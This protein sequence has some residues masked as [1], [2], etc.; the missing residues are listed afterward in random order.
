M[1]QEVLRA[2]T[3]KN[4]I[5]GFVSVDLGC[6]LLSDPPAMQWKLLPPKETPEMT[7]L[8]K[9]LP[10]QGLLRP[11]GISPGELAEREG[12]NEHHCPPGGR[13]GGDPVEA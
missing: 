2:T 8:V 10:F 5:P 1:L 3:R 4:E 7:R 13:N 11:F 6:V 12:T 9:Q